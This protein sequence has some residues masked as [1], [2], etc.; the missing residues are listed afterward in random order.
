MPAFP[1]F[2]R[3]PPF[4]PFPLNSPLELLELVT[5]RE[6][7]TDTKVQRELLGLGGD[8]AQGDEACQT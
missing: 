2:G 8:R 5:L 4:P 3:F 7:N 6:M 1:P